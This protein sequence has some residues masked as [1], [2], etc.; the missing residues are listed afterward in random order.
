MLLSVNQLSE[1]TG[2]GRHGIPKRLD[3]LPFTSGDKGAHLY[4]ST[5]A[6][7]LIYA[8][9]ICKRRA[10]EGPRAKR[11]STRCVKKISGSSASRF[12]SVYRGDAANQKLLRRVSQLPSPPN[13]WR[14]Y[15]RKRLW[16][17][18]DR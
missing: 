15:F 4:E 6:L 5:Q 8:V 11:R 17:P 13:S 10:Q 18:D 12:K 1:L 3:N 7:P 16:N 2:R 14:E 9:A